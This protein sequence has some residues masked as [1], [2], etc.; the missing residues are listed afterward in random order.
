MSLP[1]A[2]HLA[3]NR[4]AI[5]NMLKNAMTGLPKIDKVKLMQE[6]MK[7]LMQDVQHLLPLLTVSFASAAN[8]TSAIKDLQLRAET[9]GQSSNC[10][11]H[12]RHVQA[13]VSTIATTNTSPVE[14]E[15][16]MTSLRN[17]M[18]QLHDESFQQFLE[19]CGQMQ[20]LL[21][22]GLKG[23]EDSLY[24]LQVA[25]DVLSQQVM[26]SHAERAADLKEIKD[27]LASF[28]GVAA[29]VM[30]V[31]HLLEQHNGRLLQVWHP[32]SENECVFV[33]TELRRVAPIFF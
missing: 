1:K 31:D 12:L 15:Q 14:V 9:P 33:L 21:G 20:Q 16:C 3:N 18:L 2:A 6:E 13:A 32:D 30:E 25:V 26:E 17:S 29:S 5:E 23:T 8:V 27:H 4:A 28:S 11:V 10:A 24:D 19:G 22:K 7:K